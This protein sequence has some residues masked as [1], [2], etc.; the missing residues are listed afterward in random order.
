MEVFLADNLA[1]GA[2]YCRHLAE[3]IEPAILM[4]LLPGGEFYNAMISQSH[5]SDCNG[6]CY[7]CLADYSNSEFHGILDWRLALDLAALAADERHPVDLTAEYWSGIPEKA[8]RI[9]VNAVDGLEAQTIDSL[10]CLFRGK[11][12]FCVFTHPLWRTDH[13]SLINLATTLTLTSEALGLRQC[14]LFDALRRPGWCLTRLD[15][16]G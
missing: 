4:P 15:F 2:G 12:L 8:A 7:D 16:E 3:N 6:V 5:A 14:N 11:E 1:N 10:T 9:F 13:P